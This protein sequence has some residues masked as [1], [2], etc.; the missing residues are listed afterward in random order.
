MASKSREQDSGP[1]DAGEDGEEEREDADGEDGSEDGGDG[2]DGGEE[3]EDD[4]D[5]EN[6][7]SGGEDEEEEEDSH[8]DPSVSLSDHQAILSIVEDFE[9]DL[10][11]PVCLNIPREVPIP[12]CPAGHIVCKT[13][14]PKVQECPTCKREYPY[15]KFAV[16]SS[17][18]AS[19]I[20]K[21]PHKCKYQDFKCDVKK[22]LSEIVEHDTRRSAQRE[23]SSVPK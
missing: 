6:E 10:E 7:D 15:G 13:C 4:E 18:A 1:T 8:S 3:K 9:K 21:V 5:E 14:K 23:L 11:C 19:L 2:G 20:D 12:S 17:L 22:K 16:T